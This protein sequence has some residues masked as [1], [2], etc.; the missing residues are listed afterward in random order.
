MDTDNYLQLLL[1]KLENYQYSFDNIDIVK[2]IGKL[3][4]LKVYSDEY[5]EKRNS[6]IYHFGEGYL[7][8]I[9]YNIN[10]DIK[11]KLEKINSSLAQS[12]I[13]KFVLQHYKKVFLDGHYYSTTEEI[14]QNEDVYET[15][16]YYLNKYGKFI[17]LY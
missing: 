12:I 11:K 10:T 15:S 14:E 4:N 17:P 2:L 8:W 3:L 7:C 9:N 16:V 5:T 6:I 1:C 13:K